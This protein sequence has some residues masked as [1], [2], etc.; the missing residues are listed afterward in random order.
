MHIPGRN[1][2]QQRGFSWDLCILES[3][4][5]GIQVKMTLE[6]QV[7]EE[8]EGEEVWHC[9]ASLKRHQEINGGL[10]AP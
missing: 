2:S 5:M 8:E 3:G 6:T 10:L 4:C 1:E 9:L 7:E